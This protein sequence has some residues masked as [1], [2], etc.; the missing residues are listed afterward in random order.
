MG[1]CKTTGIDVHDFIWECFHGLLKYGNKISHINE[2]RNDN[3][4]ANSKYCHKLCLTN[5]QF[6]FIIFNR[7]NF[8]LKT[9]YLNFWLEVYHK[10]VEFF[11]CLHQIKYFALVFLIARACKLDTLQILI[12]LNVLTPNSAL[13]YGQ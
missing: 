6:Y 5:N 13:F 3:P 7:P 8:N 12:L 2:Q 9:I 10:L 4:L 11:V 1:I